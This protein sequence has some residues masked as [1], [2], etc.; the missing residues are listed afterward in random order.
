MKKITKAIIAIWKVFAGAVLCQ[1]L[2]TSIL[3][4]GWTYRAMQRRA[5]RTWQKHSPLPQAELKALSGND[6]LFRE[7]AAWPNWFVQPRGIRGAAAKGLVARLGGWIRAAGASLGENLRLGLLA[8][9]N[10]SVVMIVPAI[11]WELGW[12]AG[13]DNSF[14]KGYEQYYVGIAVSWIGIV[15]FLA[16]MLYLPM[17]QARQAVTGDWRA[18]YNLRTVWAVTRNAPVRAVLLAAAYSIVS[19]P[20]AITLILPNAFEKIAPST[21]SMSDSELIQ[22]LNRYYFRLAI[23]GFIAY[24]FVRWI[25]AGSYARTIVEL[26]HTGRLK[27]EDL[28]GAERHALAVLRLDTAGEASKLHPAIAA[29][30]ALS[31]PI[32]RA[33]VLGGAVFLWFTFVAQ[34]YIREFLVYHPLQ[35]FLNQPLVQLPWFRYVPRSLVQAARVAD[36]RAGES[37]KSPEN[38]R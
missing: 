27:K 35:G 16:A 28:A 34:I 15:M 19:L 13:W 12:Y 11:L 18:F 38:P 2:P 26:I 7:H 29:T 6:S 17:A 30:L 37:G 1:F 22:F 36:T 3:A 14:N 33:A 8:I 20:I 32:W 21:V 9:F 10:T 5:L 23:Y 24:V 4:V 25:A 31:R